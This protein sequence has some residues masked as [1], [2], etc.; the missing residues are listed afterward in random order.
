MNIALWIVTGFLVFGFA[1]GG[2]ALLLL[3]SAQY[4]KLGKNQHWVDDFPE[5]VLKGIGVIKICAAAGL[6]LP[7]IFD[8]AIW[9]VPLAAMG[10]MMF[11]TGAAAV[12]VV[13]REWQYFAGDLLF[14]ALAG[15]V[16]WG[17]AFGPESLISG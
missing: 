1:A 11:M 14:I 15:F 16:A 2:L 8:T 13:R 7:V 10:L 17:R 3:S 4:R 5:A 12:R 6:I 9:L